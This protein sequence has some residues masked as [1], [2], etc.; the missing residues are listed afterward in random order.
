MG[1]LNLL[2]SDNYIVVNKSLI[3]IIGLEASVLLGNLASEYD[4]WSEREELVDGFFFSTIENIENKTGLTPY[5]QRQAIQK[6]TEL[7]IVESKKMGIPA[8]RYIRINEQQ[9]VSLFN[10]KKLKNCTTGGKKTE[11][12][13]VKKLN[14]NK[15]INNKTIKED[16]KEERKKELT[17]DEILDSVSI[18]EENPDLRDT[19]I[20][21]IKMR[22]LIKKPLTDRALKGI[23][24]DTYK[25]GKG[26]QH[27][28]ILVLEQSIKNS[29]QGV[30]PLKEDNQMSSNSYSKPQ[31]FVNP[32]TQWRKEH[33]YA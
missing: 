7:G 31:E 4:Y 3:R 29:W 1:I 24:N 33:G 22:K 11:Q 28:M 23:I 9:V 19:F 8:K 13:E 5:Q 25:L 32:F 12:Q 17:F 14:S 20:D 30:F 6:L 16:K 27:Q 21:F 10:D 15:N 18:I 2:S 26:D